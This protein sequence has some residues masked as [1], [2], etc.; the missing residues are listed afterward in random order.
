MPSFDIPAALEW[1]LALLA[2]GAAFVVGI[3]LYRFIF[4][5]MLLW[6]LRANAE[7]AQVAVQRLWGPYA[8]MVAALAANALRLKA[9]DGLT[10]WLGA[11]ALPAIL[12]FAIEALRLA[13][14]DV[15]IASK[16]GT[17]IPKILKDILFGLL[18]LTAALVCL[19]SV[20]K[21]DVAPFLTTSAILSVVI[22]LA[23][24]DTLG[25]LFAG[26]AINLDRPFSIGDWVEVDG[27]K[28]QIHEITWRAT[29]ILTRQH[30]MIVMP[31]SQIAKARI[32]NFDSPTGTYGEVIELRASLHVPPNQIRDAVFEVAS[33]IPE[34]RQTPAPEVNVLTYSE[35]ALLYRV[36]VWIDDAARA[37]PL[38]GALLEGL[39]FHFKR[40]GIEM[41]FPVR[42]VYLHDAKDRRLAALDATLE[43]L[44][45]VDFMRDFEPQVLEMLAGQAR[46]AIFAPQET[47][48]RQGDPG[49]SLYIVLRGEVVLTLDDTRGSQPLARL[50]AG[51]Y[52]GEMSLLTGEPRSATARAVEDSEFLVISKRDLAPLLE[53]HPEV[54]ESISRIIAERRADM[55]QARQSMAQRHTRVPQAP[56]DAKGVED[57]SHELLSRIRAFFKLPG[58]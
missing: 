48:F 56:S 4:T 18:Y 1:P 11:L 17:P 41:P 36:I 30:Q 44:R 57:D 14:V 31:N 2:A 23:L 15:V 25:N 39:W 35:S 5:P 32:V 53:A 21:V 13:V 49:G 38:R 22:G 45:R 43:A 20:F 50:E 7:R 47:I 55:D 24:Q 19:G 42:E 37:V 51:S 6:A 33:Q 12:L 8:L 29:K 16:R 52:F 26:V 34:I 28:G 9:G 58:A 54:L 27:Q 3:A 40:K 46:H 10:W